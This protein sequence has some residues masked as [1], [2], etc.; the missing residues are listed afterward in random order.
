MMSRR[1]FNALGWGYDE[2]SDSIYNFL[3]EAARQVPAS[4]NIIDLGAG[5]CRYK[6]F[7]DHCHYVSI[8]NQCG[9][10]NW[11]YSK[12]DIV[13]D[14]VH[15]KEIADESFDYALCTTVLEHIDDPVTFFN[16]IYPQFP[17]FW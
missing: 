9:D 8:D 7:F 6:P 12:L 16:N 4:A 17:V 13:G 3:A 10:P 1:S 14:I 5:Q 2:Q 15:L 11:N